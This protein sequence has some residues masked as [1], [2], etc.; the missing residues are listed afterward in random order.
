MFT[1]FL[2]AQNMPVIYDEMN[3]DDD[4]DFLPV[5]SKTFTKQD[6]QEKSDVTWDDVS[7]TSVITY[8]RKCSLNQ[9]YNT[10]S[11]YT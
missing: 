7:F 4:D 10:Y 11:S 9:A 5:S 6:T 1:N 2:F 8:R 3:D